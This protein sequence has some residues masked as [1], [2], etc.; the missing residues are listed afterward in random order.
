MKTMQVITQY[1]NKIVDLRASALSVIMLKNFP[2]Y[3]SV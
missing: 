3:N 2:V 1:C